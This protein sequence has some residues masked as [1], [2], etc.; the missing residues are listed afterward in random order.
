MTKNYRV[1]SFNVVLPS[2]ALIGGLSVLCLSDASSDET[3][4]SDPKKTTI[5]SAAK[6][7]T[8]GQTSEK[9]S[10]A[11]RLALSAQKG[12]CMTLDDATILE[13]EFEKDPDDLDVAAQLLGFY[14]DKGLRNTITSKKR[15]KLILS[16]IHSHPEAAILGMSYCRINFRSD[17]YAEVQELWVKQV[18]KN[19]KSIPILMNAACAALQPNGA[20]ALAEKYLLQAQSLDPKIPKISEKLVEVYELSRRLPGVDKSDLA[21]KELAELKKVY[22]NTD[23]EAQKSMLLPKM[24]KAALEIP[25]ELDSADEQADLMI[26]QAKTESMKWPPE[27]NGP[28]YSSGEGMISPETNFLFYF[29]Y[30]TKGMVALKKGDTDKSAEFLL[31]SAEVYRAMNSMAQGP[32][33]SLAKAL[34]EAGRHDEVIEFLNKCGKVWKVDQGKVGKWTAEIK[35]GKIPDFGNSLYY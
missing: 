24:A 33:M 34:L 23:N 14:T 28:V 6:D 3:K 2:W 21:A 35:A 30:L 13:K 18:E 5:I 1:K 7:S 31:K 9:Y 22:K 16:L 17:I 27:T 19:P 10:V 15:E 4:L 29:G 8:S 11:V 20:L 26:S 12:R 32:N 25:G